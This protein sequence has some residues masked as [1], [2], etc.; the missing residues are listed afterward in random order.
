MRSPFRR[1]PPVRAPGL[2]LC[3]VVIATVIAA[4]GSSAASALTGAGAQ[5]AASAAPADY[6]GVDTPAGSAN[7]G[8]GGASSGGQGGGTGGGPLAAADTAKIVRTGSLQLTVSDVPKALSSARDSVQAFGGYIGASQQQ[9]SGDRLVATVTY[10]IPAAT[11]E[12]SLDAMRSLGV[13]DGEK[14]DALEVTSQMEDIAA[15]LRNLRASETALVGYATNAPK[16]SDLLE[17]Q[18]RLTDTR[19][20]IERLAAQ[21]AELQDRV[22][23][24]TLTVTFGTE[25]VA[26]AET[27]ARWDPAAEVDRATATL[28]A[29]G[30]AVVSF[31]IV[32]AIVWLPLLIVI[33]LG[34]A[35]AFVVA[36]RLGWRR[37]SDVP[38]VLPPQAPTSA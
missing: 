38:P 37:P 24:A 17:I 18:A 2:L 6:E 1:R 12:A 26:V 25:P 9:R 16:V 31:A 22:A 7:S 11:W 30:Q 19:G 20:E 35:V 15:R 33:G 27:A 8:N 10:R 29:L 34:A 23:L 5:A 21:Q 13:V 28:I 4:C 3:F 14:T 36:R 32:F